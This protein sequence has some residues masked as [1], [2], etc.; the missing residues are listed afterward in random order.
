MAK[1]REK[2]N[3][4]ATELIP[5]ALPMNER[6][7]DRERFASWLEQYMPGLSLRQRAIRLG[8]SHQLLM[9]YLSGESG[10]SFDTYMRM[11]ARV[12]A[13]VTAWSKSWQGL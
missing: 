12:Q 13:P 3:V 10:P 7:F 11:A 2:A 9:M 6:H 8:V 5:R 1:R 4:K